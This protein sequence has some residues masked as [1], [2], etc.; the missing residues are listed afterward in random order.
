MPQ[1]HW[2]HDG[3]AWKQTKPGGLYVATGPSTTKQ[4]DKGYVWDGTQWRNHY[5]KAA[6]VVLTAT[7]AAWD[8]VNLSWNSTAAGA[9][10]IVKRGGT[11]IYNNG[12]ANSFQDTVL[13][14]STGYSYTIDAYLGGTLTSSS[15]ASATTPARADIGTYYQN[16]AWNYAEIGWTD[17]QQNSV[18]QYDTYLNNVYQETSSSPSDHLS[19]VGLAASTAYT[20][21]V[22]S[23]R[24]GVEIAPRG[25]TSF[26]SPARPTVQKVYESVR[27]QYA[28]YHE[29]GSNRGSAELYY[30]WYSTNWGVQK[31]QAR[32]DFPADMRNCISI[33]SIQLRWWN[34]H[35]FLASSGVVGMAVHHNTN[36]GGS[37]G[38]STGS[39]GIYGIG[40]NYNWPAP[41]QSW[42]NGTEWFHMNDGY[43]PGRTSVKEEFRVNGAQGFELR[44]NQGGS[45]NGY[46]YA[47]N[48]VIIRVTYTCYA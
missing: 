13:M 33:D 19:G 15:S 11:V 40:D 16:L 44:T 41:R 32:W 22:V 7:A 4:V 1:V 25:Y 5:V 35:H 37:Y 8:K 10:Y 12:T 28:S 30:G 18:D 42:I 20:G 39:I 26:T 43:T 34:Q 47:S 2:V 24:G 38:G 14:P 17:S 9:T 6:P 48:D 45:Q 27:A 46:G 31:S 3:T 21:M 29:N 23:Y 36:L